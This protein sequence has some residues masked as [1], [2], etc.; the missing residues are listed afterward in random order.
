MFHNH[1][2]MKLFG[3]LALCAVG[4]MTHAEDWIPIA[5][6]DLKMTTE[7]KA[8]VASAIYLYRQVDRDDNAPDEV[9]YSRIKILTE[10]GRK[11][12]DVEIPYDGATERIRSIQARTILPDGSIVNFDGTIFEKPIV[13]GRGVKLLAKTF[14]LPNVRVGSII[15]YRYRHEL[16]VGYVF[17]S[18]WTLSD[19]LFTRHAKY[20]LSPSNEFTVRYSWPIGLPAGTLPPKKDGSRIRMEAH[21]IPAFVTEDFMPPER[22][23]KYRVDFIYVADSNSEKE[24]DAFWKKFGKQRFREVEAFVNERRAMGQAVAQI[25]T[26]ADSPETKLRKIYARTQQIRNLSFERAKSEQE[27]RREAQKEADDVTDVWKRGYGDGLEVTW[28]FLALARAAGIAADPVLVSTRNEYFFNLRMMNPAQLNSNVVLVTLDGKELFLDPGTA[29]TPFGLLPWH[30]TAVKGLR[31]NKDGG[32]WVATPVSAPADSRIVRKANFKLTPTGTL[33]GTVSVTHTGL[34]ALWLRLEERNDDDTERKQ[35]M[36]ELLQADIPTGTNVKLT[37][38]PMWNTSDPTL[39]AEYEVT[40][41]GWA[42]TTG[43]RALFAVGLFGGRQKH[44]FEHAS[45]IHPLYFSFPNTLEDD[46]TIQ[47]PADWQATSLP[48]PH[49]EDK[50]VANY[51]VEAT[52]E[53]GSLHIKRSLALNLMLLDSKFYLSLRDFFQLVRTGDEEQI[54]V[55]RGKGPTRH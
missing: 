6:E 21:D 3:A 38:S 33:E 28:L 34:E 26:A 23:L 24:P 9:I 52:G 10:E 47:L 1:A 45:R 12:A 53:Q 19:E 37:N 55:E 18:H 14:T 13:K 42:V 17:D 31:L 46:I 5:P 27:I 35:F 8:P 41:P 4:T 44:L 22:E 29:F 25:V 40:I 49:H 51:D 30:E 32:V 16:R 39:T 54:I 7:P 43:Q 36:E 15:E 11:Y 20:S 2:V 48:K 50:K